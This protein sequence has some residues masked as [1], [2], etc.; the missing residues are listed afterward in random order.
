VVEIAQRMTSLHYEYAPT[1]IRLAQ[2]AVTTGLPIN[3]PLWWIDPSDPDAQT[4]D[5]GVQ[6][7]IYLYSIYHSLLSII[8]KK[9]PSA[10]FFE[11]KRG[12]SITLH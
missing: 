10:A 12:K 11:Q 1:I 6:T 9:I 4:I 5:S 8:F 7:E 2:E 3:R